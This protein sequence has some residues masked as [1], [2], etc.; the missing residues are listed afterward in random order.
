MSLFP[1]GVGGLI[2]GSCA[3]LHWLV[4]G[5]ITGISGAGFI[6]GMAAAGLGLRL[7]GIGTVLDSWAVWK[8]ALGGAL[9]GAGTA[10]GNGCT[11]G[12]GI[13]GLA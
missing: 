3:A 13:C 5:K 4:G 12:H 9:V 10:L 11:S 2:I 7:L 1:P 8:M 6:L